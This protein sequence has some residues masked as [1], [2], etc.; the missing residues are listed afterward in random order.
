[1]ASCVPRLSFFDSDGISTCSLLLSINVS[2]AFTS[3]KMDD[4]VIADSTFENTRSLPYQLYVAVRSFV[5]KNFIRFSF[6]LMPCFRHSRMRIPG[7][8]LLCM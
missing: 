2:S 6:S 7:L 5:N 1:M 3:E 4:F 8:A